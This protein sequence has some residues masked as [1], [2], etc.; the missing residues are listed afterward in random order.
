MFLTQS[1]ISITYSQDDA[2]LD[3][4]FSLDPID[5]L[6]VPR[7]YD[8]FDIPDL[9]LFE[10]LCPES[11]SEVIVS[12]A[13][14][15]HMGALEATAA[16]PETDTMD[17]PQYIPEVDTHY[18]E[19]YF[20]LPS[21]GLSDAVCVPAYYPQDVHYAFDPV[22]SASPTVYGIT[23]SLAELSL[24]DSGNITPYTP[25]LAVP[26]T[27]P[28]TPFSSDSEVLT[29][30][31]SSESSS[32]DES[33]PSSSPSVYTT[34][35]FRSASTAPLP[36]S[37][38]R[39]PPRAHTR[40]NSPYTRDHP[41]RSS[42]KARSDSSSTPE[43]IPRRTKPRN[44]QT[45]YSFHELEAMIAKGSRRCPVDECSFTPASGKRD[46]LVRHIK[47]HCEDK[48]EE[49]VLESLV[50][51]NARTIPTWEIPD[52]TTSCLKV[53]NPRD[54][55]MRYVQ[56]SSPCDRNVN[57]RITV[58]PNAAVL[59]SESGSRGQ[60]TTLL[61]S[62][63]G[64]PSAWNAPYIGR[65][66]LLPSDL[67]SS[68]FS[69]D[70]WFME[71]FAN[72]TGEPT[73][74]DAPAPAHLSTNRL[75]RTHA[76]SVHVAV[77]DIHSRFAGH[78][79][80][81]SSPYEISRSAGPSVP[82]YFGSLEYDMYPEPMA[83]LSL[84]A[85]TPAAGTSHHPVFA[86]PAVVSE[87]TTDIFYS[88]SPEHPSPSVYTNSPDSSSSCSPSLS[89]PTSPF[90]SSDPDRVRT[91]SAQR[92]PAPKKTRRR[93]PYSSES[94]KSR[95]KTS[96][97]SSSSS[98]VSTPLPTGKRRLAPPRNIQ[99]PVDVAALV[100]DDSLQCPVCCLSNKVW[101]CC[102]VPEEMA[103]MY[104]IRNGSTRLEHKGQWM[105]GG[106]GID[107]SRKDSLIRHLKDSKEPCTADLALG[108][109]LG[110]FDK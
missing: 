49:W 31:S 109:A 79:V 5:F 63:Q 7:N 88:S 13:S 91:S 101:V 43:N 11:T 90:T 76:E 84:Q 96:R 52:Q 86:V 99:A 98:S 77:P 3:G 18:S 53:L 14:P 68:V 89:S 38:S 73:V 87:P 17:S 16:P 110:W 42:K 19:P 1:D 34:T 81:A 72:T 8:Y 85:I 95:R 61:V 33:S 80:S 46:D 64:G 62:A 36:S 25:Q 12:G 50:T 56:W 20:P 94:A 57:H 58:V 75:Y 24:L 45:N 37:S 22:P 102:G 74:A 40:R 71:N 103:G 59:K 108:E 44:I 105:V 92:S 60:S 82:A 21:P 47:T 26:I 27:S 65:Q 83:N 39:S 6:G 23:R 104:E 66:Y 48:G 2:V 10:D 55:L 69:S 41:Q 70:D 54:A 78:T 15:T 4:S 107:F 9:F 51:F 29:D 30:S 93:A 97:S 32:D 67:E 100:R 28:P 35:T 106:C